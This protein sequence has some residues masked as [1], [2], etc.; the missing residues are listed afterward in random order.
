M[1]KTG[2]R[3]GGRFFLGEK[4]AALDRREEGK[5][6]PRRMC[7]L[8]DVGPAPGRQRFS[9]EDGLRE[10]LGAMSY[11]APGRLGLVARD[12]GRG[13]VE[14]VAMR[15]GFSRPWS[16][17]ITNARD[18]KLT[19]RIWGE[20]WTGRRCVLP[21]RRFYEWSGDAGRKT[22]HAIHTGE[23]D[24]WFWIG[25]LW[26][27][28]AGP[29]GG[30]YAMITTPANAQMAFLHGRMPLILP[31]ASVE[32]FLF[33]REAPQFLVKPYEAALVI[34]PPAPQPR[35]ETLELF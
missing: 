9:W 16:K 33:S 2:P 5:N 34:D 21:V 6:G 10:L 35:E 12:S 14:P 13:G 26:E 29:E 20:A 32:E 19:G 27:D 15:W 23:T 22:K 18:D 25:G 11:A 7:N 17:S 8:Y 30:A 3:T 4:K 1:K 28:L 31:P 24:A